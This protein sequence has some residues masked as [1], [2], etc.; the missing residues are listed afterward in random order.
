MPLQRS[1]AM[2]PG[3]GNISMNVEQFNDAVKKISD[4]MNGVRGDSVD[5]AARVRYARD[6]L[7]RLLD[8]LERKHDELE[9]PRRD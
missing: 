9:D 6:R 3:F 2:E 4:A 8:D 7:D 1:Y 5:S